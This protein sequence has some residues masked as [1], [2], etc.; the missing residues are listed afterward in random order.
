MNEEIK[1]DADK[2]C[3]LILSHI[4]SKLRLDTIVKPNINEVGVFAFDLKQKLNN[5]KDNGK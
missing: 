3:D 4:D 2:L 5:L 1:K